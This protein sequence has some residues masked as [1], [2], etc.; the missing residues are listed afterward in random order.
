MTETFRIEGLERLERKLEPR[1]YESA[2][3]GALMAIAAEVQDKVAPYAPSTEANVPSG[4]GS[5]WYER[6]YGPRWMLA[7]GATVGRKTSETLGRR[8]SIHRASG[9]MK[10][11]LS[12]IASYAAFVHSAEKQASFHKRRGWRTDRDAVNEV[13]RS[14]VVDR[15]LHDA[16]RK[17]MG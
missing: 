4:P 13:G 5:R 17:W 10:V 1:A 15:I 6:G 16:F 11:V 14:S 8:W 2:M 9:R 12:N 3:E 7:S